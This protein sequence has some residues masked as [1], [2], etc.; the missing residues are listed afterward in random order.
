ME[1]QEEKHF[2]SAYIMG[3]LGNQLF[4]IFA[5]IATSIRQNKLFIFQY[6]I[7]SPS[8]T[9]R[10]TYWHNFLFHLQKYTTKDNQYISNGYIQKF[11]L[12]RIDNHNYIE[13]PNKNTNMLLFGFFQT[14]KY[15]IDYFDDIKKLMRF[16]S[17]KQD[18]KKEFNKY[19]INNFITVSIHFRFSDYKKL[20]G[21]YELLNANYY[22]KAVNNVLVRDLNKNI[23]FLYF[24]EEE[25]KEDVDEIIKKI[26]FFTFTQDQYNIEHKIIDHNIPDWKQMILMSC[27]NHNIIANSTF[28]YWGALF[29]EYNY[30]IVCY[31][32]KWFGHKEPIRQKS[33]FDMFPS[34]WDS[35][36]S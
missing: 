17:I 7:D 24:F 10:P 27:C 19:F 12:C 11:P 20:T 33:M 16:D 22:I 2:I 23:R 31:P 1:N 32:D 18:I 15:F 5:A 25:D 29:N 28:S 36:N 34:K 4:Q 30:K 9:P 35:I 6:S 21:T 26:K 13:I 8:I 3:G 14:Y